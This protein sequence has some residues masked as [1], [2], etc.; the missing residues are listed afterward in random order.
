[1]GRL[2]G[3][4]PCLI[5][6][7]T[8]NK[9]VVPVTSLLV[10]TSYFG[11]IMAALK[12]GDMIK[13][14]S[15]VET[16]GDFSKWLRKT[17]MVAKLQKVKDLKDFVPMF[18][19]GQAFDIYAEL[20]EDS[21]GD[22]TAIEDALTQ[23]FSPNQFSAY[24]ELQ[25][26][27]LKR[28]ETVDAYVSDLKR[29]LALSGSGDPAEQLVKSALVSGLPA[30]VKTILVSMSDASKLTL[31]ELVVRAR[32]ALSV[33]VSDG[34][35]CAAGYRDQVGVSCHKCGR[36]GHMSRDCKQPRP[37]VMTCFSCGKPGHIARFCMSRKSRQG[38]YSGVT[39]LEQSVT[40]GDT[41][42]H[43]SYQ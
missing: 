1:M 14:Y 38:N 22:F 4:G 24:E 7:F 32:T 23:A 16:S 28:G 12:M 2:Q 39:S 21:Q 10:V 43:P 19:S 17:V 37:R 40:P 20:S 41:Q 33:H 8:S 5:A 15:D 42:A 31:Q 25:R 3:E 35:V 9:T 36:P 29:L 13:T 18:L 11:H 6:S 26:R 27:V 30:G 34:T